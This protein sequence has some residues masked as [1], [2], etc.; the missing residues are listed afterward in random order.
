[1]HAVA[2]SSPAVT[3]PRHARWRDSVRWQLAV[4]VGAVVGALVAVWVTLPADFLRYPEWLA[5]QKADF[6]IGPVLTG[7]YWIRRRPQSPYGLMLIGWGLV[8]VLYILQSSS[9]S[10]LFTIGL[11]WE[12][13]FGL[14]T[15]VLILAFPAGR[16]DRPS[17]IVLI[18][19][20]VIVLVSSTAIQ[21]LLPQVGA[22]GSISSCRALC[23]RNELALTSDPELARDLF[24]GFSFAVLA[25]AL[26]TAALVIY[27]FVTGTPPR[28]R[29][30]AVGTPVALLFLMCEI[31]YQLLNIVGAEETGLYEIVIWV[32][33]AARATVW[34]GFLFALIAAE[35][36]AARAM[37]RLLTQSLHHPSE[38]ELE[39]MLREPLGDPQLRLQFLN[40]AAQADAERQAVKAG[41]GRDVTVVERDGI[42]AVAIEHDVQLDDDP[43]L[44]NAAGAVALLAAENAQLDA[45]WNSALQDLRE[46]RARLV[47]AVDAERRKVERNLHD[48]VQQ[49]LIAVGLEVTLAADAVG[50]ETRG[51]LDEI[52]A[53]IEE[54]L[55]ELRE[56]A[57]GIYPPALADLG[58]VSALRRIRVHSGA[59]LTIEAGTIGRH[60]PEVDSAVYYSCLEAIQNAS[61][62]GG[63]AVAITVALR[64]DAQQLNFQVTD[65]GPGFDPST[66]LSGAGLQ[67][68]RD[69]LG[70]L[71]GRLSIL[72]AP[73]K[74]TTVTGSI[75]LH[76][77]APDD[78]PPDDEAA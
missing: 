41:P 42:P 39:L 2:G 44:L 63:P 72:T 28:R 23:P 37:Q 69:R 59:A 1:M 35:L 55:E 18:A 57:R 70:A 47:R 77:T 7:L 54:A 68:M 48:G 24:T 52:G 26:T 34:Y 19:G 20:V 45:G 51:R 64:E 75:P 32:F 14:A 50:P 60:S 11:F 73:S 65:D 5:A 9:D 78:K 33:V 46:S 76:G 56:V 4:A 27:R 30:L 10:W 22:G 66:A 53:G 13:V 40:R 74:G 71:D 15:Y 61:K 12:K 25:L 17:K 21:L 29:A 49:R 62:H 8:G 6:V 3:A 67:N 38:Q 43:E 16:L 36:F 31:T 58:L